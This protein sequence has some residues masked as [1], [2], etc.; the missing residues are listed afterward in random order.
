MGNSRFGHDQNFWG[1]N[2]VGWNNHTLTPT[3]KHAHTHTQLQGT[4]E[5][6]KAMCNGVAC[7]EG[8]MCMRGS[9]GMYCMKM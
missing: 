2:L 7:P 1:Q 8:E 4:E 3:H 6:D 5:S 9:N